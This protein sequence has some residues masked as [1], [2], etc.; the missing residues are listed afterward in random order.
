MAIPVRDRLL[1]IVSDIELI[2]KELFET[3]LTPKQQR[4]QAGHQFDHS[5]IA[6]LLVSKD[7]ELRSCLQLAVEQEEIQKKM[8]AVRAEVEKQDEEIKNL[9]KHLKDAEH[10]LAT[11]IYQAKQKLA[12]IAKANDHPIASEEL[13][14]YSHRISSSHAV[15]APYNWEVGDPRRPYPTDT[16]MRAGLLGQMLNEVLPSP[17]LPP[18]QPVSSYGVQTAQHQVQTELPRPNSNASTSSGSGFQ[19]QDVKPSLSALNSALQPPATDSDPVT[20]GS[21]QIFG[22]V[23]NTCF[24]LSKMRTL[25][26]ICLSC[27]LFLARAEDVLTTEAVTDISTPN[28]TTEAPITTSSTLAPSTSTLAPTTPS[29]TTTTTQAPTSAQPIPLPPHPAQPGAETYK[30]TTGNETCLVATLSTQLQL[31]YTTQANVTEWAYLNVVNGTVSKDS[32]SC[33]ANATKQTLVIQFGANKENGVALTF[34]KNGDDHYVN[35]VKLHYVV[36]PDNFPG[37]ENQKAEVELEFVNQTLFQVTGDKSYKCETVTAVLADKA[38]VSFSGVQVDAFR[39]GS[40]EVFRAAYEC[41]ADN[42]VNNLVPIAVGCA[43]LA[44]VVIVLIAYF[45]GRR[46][47][48]RLAYQSV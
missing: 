48:R 17:L 39:T 43:L 37:A 6:E 35:D 9:Q 46:R 7:K 4:L 20:L 10:I 14:K 5:Q 24:L 28:K 42:E 8:D 29:T 19:W 30:L 44:L 22:F 41:P 2:S 45:I 47:S 26:L 11:A 40:D 31:K 34:V 1:T 16:E 13:I 32:S 3:M 21:V 25:V 18:A 15:A 12:L 36:D 23:D 33:V 38:T 27:A